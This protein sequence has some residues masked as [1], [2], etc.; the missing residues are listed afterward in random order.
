VLYHEWRRPIV[1]ASALAKEDKLSAQAVALVS[2]DQPGD[3][4]RLLEG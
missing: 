4:A 2:M 1:S 3:V